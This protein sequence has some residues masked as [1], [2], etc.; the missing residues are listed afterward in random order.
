M[1]TSN[2]SHT[3]KNSMTDITCKQTLNIFKNAKY[4]KPVNLINKTNRSNAGNDTK[5]K[6]SQVCFSD[7]TNGVVLSSKSKQKQKSLFCNSNNNDQRNNTGNNISRSSTYMQT[8]IYNNSNN[9][10]INRISM[11]NILDHSF[12]KR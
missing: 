1:K 6:F 3:S 9:N 12:G 4:V 11:K 7:D 10:K 5:N 8:N 2:K